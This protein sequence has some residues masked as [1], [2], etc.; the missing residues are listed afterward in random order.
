[1]RHGRF[2][3]RRPPKAALPLLVAA[4]IWNAYCLRELKRHDARRLPKFVWGVVI[5]AQAPFGGL[6]YLLFG[7]RRSPAA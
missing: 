5:M 2:A 6:A 7:R 1:V 3:S 4:A